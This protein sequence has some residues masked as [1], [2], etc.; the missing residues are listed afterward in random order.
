MTSCPFDTVQ[1]HDL[2]GRWSGGEV[3]ARDELVRRVLGQ[4]T[5]MAHLMRKDFPKLQVLEQTDD[6]VGYSVMRLLETLESVR[7]T[8]VRHF[9]ALAARQMRHVLIDLVRAY[10]GGRGLA[11]HAVRLGEGSVTGSLE[12]AA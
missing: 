6:A 11:A 8:S 4:I 7:P 3:D 1:M 9:Y 5:R 10:R 2:L 12:R